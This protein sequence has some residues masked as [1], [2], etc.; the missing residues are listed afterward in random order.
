MLHHL[1]LTA[2]SLEVSVP[3]YD[4]LL[5]VLGY[6][7]TLTRP[8]VAAWEGPTPE[9]LI[10]AAK[11]DQVGNR[12]QL[13]D[14]GIHHVAFEADSRETVERVGA[15]LLKVGGRV[16]EGPKEYPD[17]SANYFAVFFLDPD[18][19]KLEVMTLKEQ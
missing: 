5:G 18:G 2:S 19:V 13:Y 9:I 4:A 15:F 1:A 12:H 8:H 16:L 11:A 10:Y 17:Y 14:P 6:E 3:F 7:R